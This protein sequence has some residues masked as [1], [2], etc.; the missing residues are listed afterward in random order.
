MSEITN[1]S[2]LL[3][4]QNKGSLRDVPLKVVRQ[5][6]PKGIARAAALLKYIYILLTAVSCYSTFGSAK[7][8]VATI[9]FVGIAFLDFC[10][11]FDCNLLNRKELKQVWQ[12][13]KEYMLYILLLFVVTAVIY[14]GDTADTP[15]MKRGLEKIF[16]STITIFVAIAAIYE[17]REKAPLYT[18]YGYALF[19]AIAIPVAVKNTGSLSQCVSDFMYFMTSGFDAVG[20]MKWLELHEVTFGFGIFLIYFFLDGLKKNLKHFLVSFFFFFIG[21]K[22]IGFGG[23]VLAFIG[24]EL[25]HHMT[26]KQ[27][28]LV[29]SILMWGFIAY[30]FGYV[31]MVRSGLFVALMQAMDIDLMGRQNLY[32]YIEDFYSLSPFFLGHG[33]ESVTSIL[34][35]AGNIKVAE[36]MISKLSAL[37][38]D[39]LTMYIEMGFFGFSAWLYYKFIQFNNFCWKHGSRKAYLMAVLS[40]MY[41]GLCYSTDNVSKYFLVSIPFWICPLAY[42]LGADCTDSCTSGGGVATR[43]IASGGS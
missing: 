8:K 26:D 28:K 20:F 24:Y 22:R 19:N 30:A 36:T 18:Y 40:T 38:N 6:A 15:L 7:L 9:P 13:F 16:Y 32:R 43:A 5:D 4:T 2:N 31:V 37:H 23:V 33:F 25:S 1:S 27:V 35:N 10:F 29:C 11:R 14:I 21:F 17:F 12:W 34:K 3:P 41:L 39:Y 42:A